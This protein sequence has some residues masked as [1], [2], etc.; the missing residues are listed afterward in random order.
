VK[1]GLTTTTASGTYRWM[2]PE[3]LFP[4]N[5]EL[6]PVTRESDMYALGCL[7]IEIFTDQRPWHPLN[8]PQAMVR[9]YQ[10]ET[11]PRPKG[12]G[13]PARVLSDSL[14][15][16][17][18]SCWCREPFHRITIDMFY[19]GLFCAESTPMTKR[20]R[21]FMDFMDY[22]A[23]HQT[24]TSL[25][26]I[27]ILALGLSCWL[28]DIPNVDGGSIVDLA[29]PSGRPRTLQPRRGQQD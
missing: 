13:I 6:A 9:V 10:G 21:A 2:A 19:L 15:G 17:L 3:L 12:S 25:S 5:G 28:A 22:T 7:G 20:R 27:P 26:N 4:E 23:Q 29:R 16:L 1:T 11:P 8:D 14:W 24:Q 18:R